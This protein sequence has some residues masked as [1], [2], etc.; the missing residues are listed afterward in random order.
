MTTHRTTSFLA[1]LTALA[2]ASSCRYDEGLLIQ[3]MEGSVFIPD[4]AATRMIA[5]TDGEV[6]PVTDV[7]L[8]GPVYSRSED[9]S[10][11]LASC[12]RESLRVADDLGVASIAFPA[13]SAGIYGW[14]RADAIAAPLEVFRSA[15]TGVAEAR[16]VA[17]DAATYDQI[18]AA[19]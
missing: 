13:V 3:N 7:K 17:F 14:P 15:S 10:G 12:Y 1:V 19:L 8:I 16:L 18:R 5:Q 4:A 2:G 6:V 11:L 9:R